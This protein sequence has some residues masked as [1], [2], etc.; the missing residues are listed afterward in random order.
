MPLK[1]KKHN[2]NNKTFFTERK[3]VKQWSS[4]S[5][6]LVEFSKTWLEKALSNLTW[7]IAA[8]AF[9]CWPRDLLRS[10]STW[11]IIRFYEKGS[12]QRLRIRVTLNSAPWKNWGLGSKPFYTEH[13]N[14]FLKWNC[15]NKNEQFM[16]LW[17]F[18]QT[19]PKDEVLNKVV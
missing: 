7:P 15:F 16:F 9:M 4:F 6:E 11:I 12:D 17:S 3:L 1:K 19:P 14:I 2:N 5:R 18:L 13:I 10:L 8:P